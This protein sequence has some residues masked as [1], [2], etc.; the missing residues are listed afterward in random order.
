MGPRECEHLPDNSCGFTDVL[1][2]DCGGDD[3]EE[4]GVYVGGE[5][6]REEGLPGTWGTVEEDTGGRLHTDSAE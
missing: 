1:V 4:G 6:T 2:H 5:G 3:F